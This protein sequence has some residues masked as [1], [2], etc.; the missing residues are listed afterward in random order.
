MIGGARKREVYFI[1]KNNRLF[2]VN[3]RTQQFKEIILTKRGK[4]IF[5]DSKKYVDNFKTKYANQEFRDLFEAKVV[6]MQRRKEDNRQIR[7]TNAR[8]KRCPNGTRRHPKTMLCV[9]KNQK[10]Q[11]KVINLVSEVIS[12]KVTQKRSGRKSRPSQATTISSSSLN[13]ELSHKDLGLSRRE[14]FT[15]TCKVLNELKRK[16]IEKTESRHKEVWNKNSII[17]IHNYVPFLNTTSHGESHFEGKI[18]KTNQNTL[19]LYYGNEKLQ[20]KNLIAKGGFGS[21][22]EAVLSDR[23]IVVKQNL[24]IMSSE[25]KKKT[26]EEIFYEH[27]KESI[28]HNE[29]F[30]QMRGKFTKDM[31]RI[32]K[33][34]FMSKYIYKPQNGSELH[35]PILGMEKIQYSMHSFFDKVEDDY[36]NASSKAKVQATVDN[37]L[38]YVM[39]HMAKLLDDLQERFEF[40]HR[41]L[42]VGNVMVDMTKQVEQLKVY[43]IDFGYS[44]LVLDGMRINAEKIGVYRK[45]DSD[46]DENYKCHDLRMFVLSLMAMKSPLLRE[47]LTPKLYKLMRHLYS[48]ITGALDRAKVPIK[49]SKWWRGYDEALRTV[50]TPLFE[51]KNFLCFLKNNEYIYEVA[52]SLGISL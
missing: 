45:Y 26:P 6:E 8:R 52:Q 14:F 35:I 49:R 39:I 22:H 2:A 10:S 31:A 23:D 24:E 9:K 38:I 36:I 1:A 15:D 13:V 7:R 18:S 32:P 51:P 30:C 3:A 44:S 25:N 17:K 34:L 40:V 4:M 33:P 20:I 46:A 50:N 21:I 27:Y 12:P 11:K 16:V 48:N 43:I 19:N 5:A 42:H 37:V 29:L 28:I 41:D 47:I